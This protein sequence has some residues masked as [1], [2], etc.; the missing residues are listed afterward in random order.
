MA[1]LRAK[2]ARAG[3][4]R[5]ARHSSAS[6]ETAGDA[7][8][9]QQAWRS[10]GQATGELMN[11]RGTSAV[12]LQGKQKSRRGAQSQQAAAARTRSSRRVAVRSG[13][14][15]LAGA[16]EVQG[17]GGAR[18]LQ[19]RGASGLEQI[20]AAAATLGSRQPSGK[21]GAERPS[22]SLQPGVWERL[23]NAAEVRS[24][25]GKDGGWTTRAGLGAIGSNGGAVG[26]AGRSRSHSRSP[27]PASA[28][29]SG[30]GA[31]SKRGLR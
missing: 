23:L 15:E 24:A 1:L 9:K 26:P 11:S 13:K 20:A 29:S 4:R 10:S 25:G 14:Q 16:T 27:S 28:S 5:Q 3:S 21:L 12:H 2:Q 30:A 17:T 19:P 18:G 6:P 31:E 7:A 8:G 22:N